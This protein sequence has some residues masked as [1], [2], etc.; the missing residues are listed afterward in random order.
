MVFVGIMSGGGMRCISVVMVEFY[1]LTWMG[2][3]WA[4]LLCDN[5]LSAEERV[6]KQFCRRRFIK[7]RRKK[8]T[9]MKK[10]STPSPVLLPSI[11]WERSLGKIRHETN[12]SLHSNSQTD[13]ETQKVHHS[14]QTLISRF[15]QGDYQSYTSLRCSGQEGKG[16][17]KI[18]KKH[19][20]F[21]ISLC[22]ELWFNRATWDQTHLGGWA[23]ALFGLPSNGASLYRVLA[24][25]FS[26]ALGGPALPRSPYPAPRSGWPSQWASE[27]SPELG[28]ALFNLSAEQLSEFLWWAPF[29]ESQSRGQGAGDGKKKTFKKEKK[30]SRLGNF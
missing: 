17:K 10:K 11:S 21:P 25:R 27:R 8:L 23:A 13:P 6:W 5:S 28:F 15:V 24:T 2:F 16:K 29:R 30:K 22:L 26:L 14:G 3:T 4:C 7:C 19:C 20:Y 1:F 9:V 18:N 12:S